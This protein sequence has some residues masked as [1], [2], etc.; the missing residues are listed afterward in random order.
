[1]NKPHHSPDNIPPRDPTQAGIEYLIWSL[2]D[3]LQRLPVTDRN[4]RREAARI[5]RKLT[6]LHNL[7]P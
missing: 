5:E 2:V 3:D 4:A 1:M 6:E 7:K